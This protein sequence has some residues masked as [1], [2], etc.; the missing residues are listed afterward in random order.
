M[1]LGKNTKVYLKLGK[2]NCEFISKHFSD[3]VIFIHR[4]LNLGITFCLADLAPRL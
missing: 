2:I 3:F 4:N 1:K